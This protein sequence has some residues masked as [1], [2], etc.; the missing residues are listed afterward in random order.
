MYIVWYGYCGGCTKLFLEYKII[1]ILEY[2]VCGSTSPR[3][4]YGNMFCIVYGA[5]PTVHRI[6]ICVSHPIWLDDPSSILWPPQVKY[7][8]EN[9]YPYHHYILSIIYT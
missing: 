6:A 4:L 1:Y 3:I 8:L 7:S 2:P 5:R 9:P